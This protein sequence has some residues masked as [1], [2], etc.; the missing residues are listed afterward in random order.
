MVYVA[1]VKGHWYAYRSERQP[2]H[3][4]PVKVYLGLASRTMI[5]VHRRKQAARQKK[6]KSRSPTAKK[7]SPSEKLDY[8][9]LVL[10]LFD[11]DLSGNGQT[12]FI[13]DILEKLE[14]IYG[15]GH[16]KQIGSA[17]VALVDS[18]RLQEIS[19]GNYQRRG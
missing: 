9:K 7:N 6:Q 19:P 12:W 5:K 4:Y 11:R 8:M 14:H 18:G 16:E 13:D 10:G 15:S 2:G 3:K 1:Q 17:V